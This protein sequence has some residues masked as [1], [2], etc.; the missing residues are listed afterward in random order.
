MRARMLLATCGGPAARRRAPRCK[1][2]EKSQNRGFGVAAGAPRAPPGVAPRPASAA[3]A[4]AAHHAPCICAA[5]PAQQRER[6]PHPVAAACARPRLLRPGRAFMLI[7]LS[8][9]MST[10]SA[11]ARASPASAAGRRAAAA[12]FPP[13][14][15]SCPPDATLRT[16]GRGSE[17]VFSLGC[18][19]GS[20][21]SRAVAGRRAAAA[22]SLPARPRWLRC[23]MRPWQA[24]GG[25]RS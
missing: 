14:C 11:A 12:F 9:A 7:A 23:P 24:G 20:V 5:D 2:S 13:A 1:V 18:S 19:L 8:S 17:V 10:R 4:T 22:H 6:V 25:D 3:R 16:Q 21:R 15:T